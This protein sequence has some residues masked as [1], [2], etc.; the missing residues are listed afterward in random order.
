MTEPVHSPKKQA[1]G[2]RFD[3]LNQLHQK[4]H[5][6]PLVMDMVCYP[7]LTQQEYERAGLSI[8]SEPEFTLFSE[9]LHFEQQLKR[10]ISRA[11]LSL[12]RV[13]KDACIGNIYDI[14]RK[15]F[16]PNYVI[17]PPMPTAIP[18]SCLSVY[19]KPLTLAE[20]QNILHSYFEGIKQTIFVCSMSDLDALAENLTVSLKERN[21]CVQK[22]NLQ[23][24]E[25]KNKLPI[26]RNRLSLFQFEAIYF[27]P[28]FPCE[29]FTVY[30]GML[31]QQ[32][33]VFL[34]R[35]SE[36]T[37]FNLEQ[38]F[39]EH[40][41]VDKH[42]QVR[43]GAGT[44]KTYS[45]VSRIAFLCHFSSNSGVFAPAD[46]I[47]MLTF[48]SDAA[49]NMKVRLKQMFL[50]YF[51]LTK[52]TKYLELVSDIEK[53]RIS[54]IHS[55]AGEVFRN[56][57]LALG[58]G[59][60]F[61]TISGYYDRNMIFE[62]FFND[63]LTKKNHGNPL[64]FE[65]LPVSIYDFQKYLRQIAGML[66]NKGCDI[67]EISSEMFGTPPD[68]MPYLQDMIEQVV[69]P[70]EQE[71][72]LFLA[73]N[74]QLHLSE[75]MIYLRKC[76]SFEGFNTNLFHFKYV[77]I[78]E[79]QDTDDAQISAF[80]AMQ[81]KMNFNFF[82]VGDL[83]QSIYRFRGATMDAFQQMGKLFNKWLEYHLTINYRTDAR[84]L[85]QFDSVFSAMGQQGVLP[86]HRDA[87]RLIGALKDEDIPNEELVKCIPY[88]QTEVN[89]GTYYDKLFKEVEQQKILLEQRMQHQ[90]LSL[91]E[92]TI[93]ILTRTNYQIETV[94]RQARKRNFHIESTSGGD[95][96]EDELAE[97]FEK[98]SELIHDEHFN[99][100]IQKINIHSKDCGI[101]QMQTMIAYISEYYQ[102][103]RCIIRN[104]RNVLDED[105]RNQRKLIQLPYGLD[106]AHNNTQLQIYRHLSE[107]IEQEMHSVEEFRNTGKNLI[108][109]FFSSA[110]AFYSE[111]DKIKMHSIPEQLQELAK[112]W[113]N[114][115]LHEL[116]QISVYL[117]S[118]YEYSSRMVRILDYIDQEAYHKKVLLF[119]NFPETFQ[120]YEKALSKVFKGKCCFFRR[121]MNANELE[122][123]T[124]RFQTDSK[125]LIMLSDESG[126]EGRNFQKADILIH[127][128]LP[129]NANTLEQRIGRLDRIGRDCNRPVI[130][131]VP[132]A[133]E[134]L[135]EDLFQVWNKGLHIFEQSQN[136]LEIIMNEIDEK[137]L[138]SVSNDMKYG[139]SN[140]IPQLMDDVK[141]L[142]ETVK[143][144]QHFD[145][146]SYQYQVLNQQLD[147][148]VRLYAENET[149]L[150]ASSM[151]GWADMTGF[152]GKEVSDSV[153][154]FDR[155]SF[156][157][158]STKHTHF[159]PPDMK[160]EIPVF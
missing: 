96:Y 50:N 148:V 5:I 41:P 72:E 25:Q 140:M 6:D 91:S 30:N 27:E 119:T 77:F 103:E 124:Y 11:Y 136:G 153:I 150:F 129:W 13:A 100:M 53:M 56:T 74:N 68:E 134:T 121:G 52:N 97:S 141:K 145:T 42:I 107:W 102:L 67:K 71:Y 89:N 156:S 7:F 160:S 133:E 104:R 106:S 157:V 64:F 46:E 151:L 98:I 63:Y 131:V 88:Y 84:I 51:V 95:L 39:V 122:L 78:D 128:D 118:P 49:V 33:T 73:E 18:Y 82:I 59:T 3:L 62:R 57:S 108:S 60:N 80:L 70:T 44:G 130:S 54:T 142:K 126:G 79:F 113:K 26:R 158:G 40:A 43:A 83:K 146:A 48:T 37:L 144:E 10:K 155:S 93:A 120:H 20:I 87:E 90:K 69:I 34:S 92:R 99:D 2:Y 114:E 1:R 38:Y 32:Q 123:Q 23:F 152:R 116:E 125:Y 137:I 149:E 75:Y 8:V 147:R 109:A 111:L 86:Y 143:K 110:S 112:R 29:N 61:T 138:Q 94:L 21:L 4:Y 76:I 65:T 45:I 58:I 9:D 135:E 15:H 28:M 16:E 55:F 105:A 117:Q 24:G 115:E 139:L 12:H 132:F 31:S 19:A 36:L 154:R 66:Y 47:A 22:E 14:C 81:E 127:I 17:K 101:S 35:L 85:N 159:V